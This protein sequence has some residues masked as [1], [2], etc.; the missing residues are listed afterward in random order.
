[1]AYKQDQWQHTWDFVENEKKVSSPLRHIFPGP[2]WADELENA[3]LSSLHTQSTG[4]WPP[5]LCFQQALK[6]RRL[7]SNASR[8]LGLHITP[9]VTARGPRVFASLLG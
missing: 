6:P 4:E 3:A 1:M 8:I 5:P 9:G 2:L 7:P